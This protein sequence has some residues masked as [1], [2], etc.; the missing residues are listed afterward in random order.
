MIRCRRTHRTC[1]PQ[2]HLKL[3]LRSKIAVA[4]SDRKRVEKSLGIIPIARAVFHPGDCIRISRKEALDQFWCDTHHRHRRN[5]VQINFQSRITDALHNFAEIAVEPFLADIL[6]IERRQHQH[7]RAT[8]SD[9]LFGEL[10]RFHDRT[11][12]GSRHHARR[13]DPGRDQLVEQTSRVLPTTASS[14]RCSCRTRRA[15]SS[16]TATTYNAR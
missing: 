8:V 13:I 9:S 6:V 16:V 5:V 11:A 1:E 15:R 2:R 3:S 10:D 4:S 12:T 14:P 7:A